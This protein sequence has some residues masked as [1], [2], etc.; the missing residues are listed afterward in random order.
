MDHEDH[1]GRINYQTIETGSFT[2]HAFNRLNLMVEQTPVGDTIAGNGFLRE[3]LAVSDKVI[4]YLVAH[5]GDTLLQASM[6][7]TMAAY[8]AQHPDMAKPI[9]VV[10]PYAETLTGLQEKY[11][12][13]QV[14]QVGQEN[15]SRKE[16]YRQY[17]EHSR[18]YQPKPIFVISAVPIQHHEQFIR[19]R[20]SNIQALLHVHQDRFVTNV[21]P[22]K[23]LDFPQ[24]EILSIPARLSRFLEISLGARIV[25]DPSGIQAITPI[26]STWKDEQQR[27]MHMYG[28]SPYGFHCFVES[29]SVPAKKF[30]VDQIGDLL[31]AMVGREND[32]RALTKQVVFIEDPNI[33]NEEEEKRKRRFELFPSSVRQ[34]IIS[35]RGSVK[36]VAILLSLCP[37]TVLSS[38]T[39]IAVLAETLGIETLVLFTVAD[40]FLWN[41][42]GENFHFLASQ[43]ALQVHQERKTVHDSLK[44]NDG[45]SE[46]T[47][48]N[49]FSTQDILNTWNS[50]RNSRTLRR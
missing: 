15:Q 19:E 22:W 46:S 10:T 12:F 49:S 18:S 34:R 8:Y 26:S 38:D 2:Q 23:T 11:P 5:I 16:I 27:L 7:D 9:E 17:Y 24:A 25:A 30:S 47:V 20:R 35:F 13:V 6:I 41:A 14:T 43:Q 28:L 4:I 45:V 31:S 50:M 44:V 32:E 37:Q 29:G 36:D 48:E 42:G 39:G 33:S 3:K 21:T 1:I 40:P